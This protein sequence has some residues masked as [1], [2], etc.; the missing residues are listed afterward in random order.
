LYPSPNIIP[1]IKTKSIRQAERVPGV[2]GSVYGVLLAKL[3]GITAAE[4]PSRKRESNIK[5]FGE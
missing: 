5:G 2:G 1:V 4:R 3:E